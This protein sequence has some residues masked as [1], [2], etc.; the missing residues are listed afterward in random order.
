MAKVVAA[1]NFSAEEIDN[2]RAAGR[3]LASLYRDVRLQVRTGV[4]TRQLN[5]WFA[6]E[7]TARGAHAT[8]LD[9]DVNFPGVICISVNDMVV[10]GVPTDYA[11]QPGDVISFDLVI[12]VGGMKADSAFTMLTD[13]EAPTGAKKLLLDTTKKSLYA[14]IKAIHGDVRTGD[15]GAAVETVLDRARLGVVRDLVGHGIGREMHMAPDIPNYGRR[16]SGVLVPVGNA[17]AI[18][19][20]ATLG[21]WRVI[22]DPDDPTGWGYKTRDG[23]LAA[24]FEHTV[25]LGADGPEIITAGGF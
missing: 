18:E 10:H 22:N 1:A 9:D 2:M 19:P 14:G 6:Q 21:T 13:D 16:H 12:D 8:Y 4:T 15:I 7:I 24:H 3:I 23:S 5:D 20:M 25:L 11:L 17:I